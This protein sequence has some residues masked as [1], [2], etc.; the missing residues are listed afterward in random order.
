MDWPDPE[1][2]RVWQVYPEPKVRENGGK[3]TGTTQH[4]V[5]IYDGPTVAGK[6]IMAER[7]GNDPAHP[8][9]QNNWNKYYTTNHC[10]TL[11]RNDK[12]KLQEQIVSTVK[13]RPTMACLILE[14]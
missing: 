2:N 14:E 6:S 5:S 8:R 13:D 7:P 3:K 1:G 4:H 12:K 11:N 9:E 10:S